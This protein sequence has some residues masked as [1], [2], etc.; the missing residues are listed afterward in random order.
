M[1]QLS[2]S[3]AVA[4]TLYEKNGNLKTIGEKY[5]PMER[6]VISADT[7]NVGNIPQ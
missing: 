5:P 3:L 1:A 7:T 4:P 6:V 2:N